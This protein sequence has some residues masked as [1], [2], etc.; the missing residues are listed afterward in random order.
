MPNE[1]NLSLE[2]LVHLYAETYKRYQ[3]SSPLTSRRKGEKG[4]ALNVVTGEIQNQADNVA[5][6]IIKLSLIHI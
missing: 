1:N 5:E 6:Y 4:Q 3:S 2:A